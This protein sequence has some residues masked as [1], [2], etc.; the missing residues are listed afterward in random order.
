MIKELFISYSKFFLKTRKYSSIA[1]FS[2]VFGA[3]SETIAIF[4]LSEI[5]K[6][7]EFK[8]SISF[9]EE[10]ILN[11]NN[12]FFYLIIFLSFSII[13]ASIYFISNKYTVKS[14]SKLERIIRK[15]ITDLTLEI[16]W[17]Y[18]IQLDQGEISK[19]STKSFEINK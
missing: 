18:F 11:N 16:D 14:K 1:L 15:E 10:G 9:K 3:I 17:P 2:G 13:S 4:Y 6:I 5:I 12:I 19:T 8:N 7:I